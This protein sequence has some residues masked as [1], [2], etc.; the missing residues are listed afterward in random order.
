MSDLLVTLP[1]YN[2]ALRLKIAVEKI[3][4]SL[5]ESG[6]SYRLAIAEDGS[7]D[8]TKEVL[9]FLQRSRPG[10]IVQSFDQK[11]GRGYA[12]RRLWASTDADIYAFIDTDLSAEPRYL[13]DLVSEIRTGADVAIGSR[14]CD[15]A[16]VKRPPVRRW[17]SQEYNWLLRKSFD[18]NIQDHQCGLKV[19]NRRAVRQVLPLCFED[20]WFWDTEAL[21][22]A[23]KLGLRVVEVP[24]QWEEKKSMRTPVTRLLSDVFLHGAG[25]IRLKGRVSGL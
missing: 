22:Y 12:L 10:L 15:G 3:E 19:F 9:R 14:Y 8:G 6:I 23:V 24:I 20:S 18:E 13:L 21:V 17:V 16:L 2:E 25:L 4:N 7:D 5:R 11:M 1:V